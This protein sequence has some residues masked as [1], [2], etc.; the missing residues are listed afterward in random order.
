V[1]GEARLIADAVVELASDPV[2]RA[3]FGASGRARFLER[4]EAAEWAR[5][6]RGVYEAVL[7]APP[8]R[9]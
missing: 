9:R 1:R 6:L 7:A 5:C 3:Q 2:L 4:F 8:S